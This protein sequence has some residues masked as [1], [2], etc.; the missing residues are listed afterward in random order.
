[1]ALSRGLLRPFTKLGGRICR[2]PVILVTLPSVTAQHQAGA[3]ACGGSHAYRV[4]KTGSILWS[5]SQHGHMRISTGAMEGGSMMC[6]ENTVQ[7]Q[8]LKG[9]LLSK[10]LSHGTIVI[11]PNSCSGTRNAHF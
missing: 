1:M 8:Y 3:E 6:H 4:S 9:T 5:C 2:D 11:V 10:I 7:Q